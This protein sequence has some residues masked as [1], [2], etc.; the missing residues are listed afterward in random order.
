MLE[1]VY[2]GLFDLGIFTGMCFSEKYRKHLFF[3]LK[4]SYVQVFEF[5]EIELGKFLI[6]VETHL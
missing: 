6:S 5:F 4:E 2:L 3:I 1:N